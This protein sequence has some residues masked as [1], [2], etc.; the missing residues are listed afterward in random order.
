M[1][2]SDS[3]TLISILVKG[4]S[5]YI[6]LII[7]LKMFGKRSLAKLNAF[8]FIV[9]IA[10]GS[11]LAATL[12]NN[13]VTVADGILSIFIVLMLQYFVSNFAVK[14]PYLNNLIKSEPTLLYH[15]GEF[16]DK[17]LEKERVQK[18]EIFQAARASG[19]HDLKQ[20]SQVILETNGTL[21]VVKK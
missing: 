13:Q 18:K 19:E 9:T 16:L 15:N 17:A 21:S 2:F 11:I 8:D 7:A 1:L 12:T 14:I 6:F 5:I 10:L 4:V 3:S 20:V